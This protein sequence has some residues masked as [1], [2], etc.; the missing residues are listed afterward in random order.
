MPTYPVVD[1][2]SCGGQVAHGLFPTCPPLVPRQVSNACTVGR[3]PDRGTLHVIAKTRPRPGRVPGAGSRE[4]SVGVAQIVVYEGSAW[5]T[6]W[7]RQ[8]F[9]GNEDGLL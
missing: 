7:A 8:R 1:P 6:T 5:K 9:L 3:V 4:P 2:V